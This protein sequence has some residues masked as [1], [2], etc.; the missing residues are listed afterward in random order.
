MSSWKQRITARLGTP[1]LGANSA[2]RVGSPS[3]GTELPL[4]ERRLVSLP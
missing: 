1:L 3:F 2:H 4:I